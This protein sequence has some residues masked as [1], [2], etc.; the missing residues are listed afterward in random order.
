MFFR[1]SVL[2]L[3]VIVLPSVSA[4]K[5]ECYNPFTEVLPD[6]FSAESISV[7]LSNVQSTIQ[8]DRSS[9]LRSTDFDCLVAYEIF[10]DERYA[11]Y[12]HFDLSEDSEIPSGI[13][14]SP[15]FFPLDEGELKGQFAS[16]TWNKDRDVS[17]M[18]VYSENSGDVYRFV[19]AS[20]DY[21][22]RLTS[23]KLAEVF[24]NL[25]KVCQ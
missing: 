23:A 2:L 13:E 18:S 19:V 6:N 20:P 8:I 22:D 11:G 12:M 17:V 9:C 15:Y 10:M 21:P 16:I 7:E 24:L 25:A 14:E 5:A 3:A 1:N 4:A